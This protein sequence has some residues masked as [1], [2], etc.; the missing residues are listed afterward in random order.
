MIA[1]QQL[2]GVSAHRCFH[3][4]PQSITISLFAIVVSGYYWHLVMGVLFEV[5]HLSSFVINKDYFFE[6]KQ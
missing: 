1:D 6:L 3:A 5:G 2:V 4:L